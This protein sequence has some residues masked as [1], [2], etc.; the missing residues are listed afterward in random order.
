MDH[1]G[2]GTFFTINQKLN[3][4]K[5]SVFCSSFWFWL[6]CLRSSVFGIVIGFHHIPNRNTKKTKYQI[7]SILKFNYSIM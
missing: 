7:L 6:F 5:I 2:M 4:T 1:A 3:R